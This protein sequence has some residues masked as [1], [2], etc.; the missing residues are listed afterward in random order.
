MHMVHSSVVDATR[1]MYSPALCW[2]PC[3]GSAGDPSAWRSK[4]EENVNAL[5]VVTSLS[6]NLLRVNDIRRRLTGWRSPV[7]MLTPLPIA[8]CCPSLRSLS[9]KAH[10]TH[11]NPSLF[12]TSPSSSIIGTSL[13]SSNSS[14]ST[15]RT[16]LCR[17]CEAR[18][19]IRR[20][21][22]R[23]APLAH[24]FL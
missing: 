11:L 19:R 1:D 4:R 12:H 20:H 21:C 2:R 3:A 9:L 6:Q 22:S 10:S 24:T 14:C 7:G 23:R 18:A 5:K 8:P 13:T 15:C 16:T 17:W